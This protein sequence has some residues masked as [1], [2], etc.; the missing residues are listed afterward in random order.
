MY[1]VTIFGRFRGKQPEREL[2]RCVSHGPF[3]CFRDSGRL[4]RLLKIAAIDRI[5]THDIRV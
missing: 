4:E 3:V 1:P 5:Q 2:A